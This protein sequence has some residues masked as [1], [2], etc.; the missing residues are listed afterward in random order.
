[1]STLTNRSNHF[2]QVQ[3][4]FVS[5][6]EEEEKAFQIPIQIPVNGAMDSLEVSS[7]IS[8]SK[9]R[10]KVSNK[11]DIPESKLDVAYKLSIEPKGDLPH[12]LSSA[13]HLL[14]MISTADQHLSGK[15]KSRSKKPFAIVIVDK[16]PK[17]VAK[18]GGSKGGSKVSSGRLKQYC[19]N[20]ADLEVVA[21]LQSARKT[22]VILMQRLS[23]PK[24]SQPLRRTESLSLPLN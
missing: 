2:T 3:S 9:F 6:D 13:K 14:Q 7:T 24:Q 1:V 8:W 19:I 20:N 5:V 4:G 16:T 23:N 17:D 11:M 21:R 18:K 10:V 15:V 12:C 22:R